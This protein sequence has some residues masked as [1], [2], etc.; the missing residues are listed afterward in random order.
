MS[1]TLDR[2]LEAFAGES[3]A[4][5]KYI[6]FA[7]KADKEGYPQVANLFRAAAEAETV[8]ALAHLRAM[9]G[10]HGTRENLEE[11]IAGETHEFRHMYPEMIETARAEGD[12]QALRSFELANAVEK[13]HANLYKGLLEALDDG[14]SGR[15]PYF[16]CPVCGH[17]SG[18]EAPETCP[19]CGAKGSLYRRVD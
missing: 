12:R 14:D 16:V 3:Q 6:A 8:H 10:V 15:Y 18:H 4:N 11:A 9:G 17:T 13:I 7:E 19:V 5:R 2:L 1:E